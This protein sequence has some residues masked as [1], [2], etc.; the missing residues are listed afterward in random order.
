MKHLHGIILGAAVLGTFGCQSYP[1]DRIASHRADF[2]SWPPDVQA[3]VR[4][5]RIALGYTQEQ[6]LVALG[7]PT[8][9]TRAG[10]PS[11]LSEVWVY[12]KHAPRLSIG[13]GGADFSG[14]TAAAGGVSANGIKLGLDE[15]GRVLFHSGRVADFSI[16]VR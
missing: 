16:M 15:D 8:L 14:H 1:T 2:N 13:I 12:N 3:N 11:A 9:E 10:D 7:E 6:V 5:G 4:A